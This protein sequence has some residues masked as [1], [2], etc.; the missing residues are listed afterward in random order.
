MLP[1]PKRASQR[2][3]CG[4]VVGV[5]RRLAA[6][7]SESRGGLGP[8]FESVTS[9]GQVPVGGA[10]LQEAP[11]SEGL[12]R[13]GGLEEPRAGPARERREE[14]LGARPGRPALTCSTTSTSYEFPLLFWW[15]R[16][17]EPL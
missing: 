12:V 14:A 1:D 6:T 4:T 2:L 5:C 3:E 11:G 8:G 13:G 10:G 9:A 17:L 15:P 16:N 7:G